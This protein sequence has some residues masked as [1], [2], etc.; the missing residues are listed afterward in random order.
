MV[1]DQPETY[2]VEVL[3][4]I[5][6]N[7]EKWV[8][9]SLSDNPEIPPIRLRRIKGSVPPHL[10]QLRSGRD[11]MGIARGSCASSFDHDELRSDDEVSL[12][13]GFLQEVRDWAELYDD[14]E[15]IDHVRIATA[16][17]KSVRALEE[18]GFL[19]FG[20]REIRCLEGGIGA[21]SPWPIVILRVLRADNA[22]I[23][24]VEF[25]TCQDD[26]QSAL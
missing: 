8:A 15:P 20:A 18:S 12:V 11:V 16:V 19:I 9:K 26:K 5:K 6:I 17:S 2:T 13:G 25:D 22:E 4:Q 21:P 1:D 10:L 24:K 14:L 3:Q 7:H 23:W